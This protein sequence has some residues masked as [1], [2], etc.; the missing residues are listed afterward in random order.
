MMNT[1]IHVKAGWGAAIAATVLIFVVGMD[2]LMM[3][4]ATS[5]IVSE[6]NTNAGMVQAAIALI[7]LV[8]APFY[9][10]AAKLGDIHGKKKLFVTGLVLYA[11]AELI[12]TLAP[13]MVILI[14]G[15]SILRGI[16]TV[17]TI[18][19]SV[20][21]LIANYPD[22]GRRGQAFAMYGVGG[23]AAVLVGPLL[24][25]FMAD[26]LSW[27]VPFGVV[28]LLVLLTIF[29]ARSMR[30]TERLETRV[31]WGGTALAFLAIA[32]VILGSMLG[33]GYGWWFARR[34]FSLGNVSFNPLGLSPAPILIAFGVIVAVILFDR[35]F[36]IEER[37]GQP[38]FSMKL[39]DNR[40]FS[41]VW[42][43]GALV[44]IISGAMSFI[45]PVF[46]Q[47]AIGFDGMQTASVMVSFSIGSIILGFASGSLVQKMQPRTL[48]QVFLFTIAAGLVWLFTVVSLN[49]TVW[50]MVLPMFVAGA[51]FGVIGSQL[52]NI[53]LSTLSPE[54]QGEGS[55]FA[56]MGKELGVG[57]G[58]AIIGS[59]LFS[60][61]VSGLVDGVAR[62]TRIYLSPDERSALILQLED[63]AVPE[64][65][66][67][68]L[69]Q[70]DMQTVY[71]DAY[72]SAFQSVLGV[73]V[74][75]LLL[76]LLAAS[77]IPKAETEVVTAPTE[78][79]QDQS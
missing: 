58:A 10:T 13:N 60:L 47:Q 11:V 64:Q 55:G 75:V 51:G 62:Q 7:S 52:P 45:L 36:R 53:Q 59:I 23:V 30:E 49:V 2:L 71:E 37:G 5:A 61:A 26:N 16:A 33:G 69:A 43:T 70:L 44:F 35:V 76:A 73:L 8:A 34:P 56:E 79:H 31:D 1:N 20:G 24:M 3:P 57:L 12:T 39:F 14:G 72:V 21:L 19:A 6:F 28:T 42:F 68:E 32:P 63:N 29:L 25:G 27:R 66:R 67:A 54:L 74:G 48:M 50:Q 38:L 46:L 9:I 41:T 65:A 18:P 78:P 77:F 40:T 17:L 4:I 22:E 15:W